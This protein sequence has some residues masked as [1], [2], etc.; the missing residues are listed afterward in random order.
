MISDDIKCP[1]NPI[2]SNPNTN[3]NPK[4]KT[5]ARGDVRQNTQDDGFEAFWNA[6]PRK[7][8]DIKQAYMEYRRVLQSGVDPAVLLQAATEKAASLSREDWPYQPSAEKWLANKGWLEQQPK[9][10]K[11]GKKQQYTTAADYEPPNPGISMEE[12]QKR[13]DQI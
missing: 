2:Q 11:S 3:P 7:T 4:E 8:G 12:L 13:I 10:G 6:Y 1:R 5:R 9:P